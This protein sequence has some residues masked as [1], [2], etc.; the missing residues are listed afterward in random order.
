MLIGQCRLPL[1]TT[2]C[3]TSGDSGSTSPTTPLTASCTATF[4]ISLLSPTPGLTSL[5]AFPALSGPDRTSAACAAAT[6]F[7]NGTLGL[8]N[9]GSDNENRDED[10]LSAASRVVLD[11]GSEGTTPL[12]G[13]GP[14]PGPPRL[15]MP[16]LGVL[17]LADAS[18]AEPGD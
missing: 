17:I 6:A 9:N 2:T 4:N 3:F 12:P 7:S 11:V 16:T 13:P 1:S 18:A 15:E 8:P 14:V 10:G 5:F